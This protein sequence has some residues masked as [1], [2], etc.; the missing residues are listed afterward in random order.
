MVAA[1][2]V[3]VQ[4]KIC[5]EGLDGLRSGFELKVSTNSWANWLTFISPPDS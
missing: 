1:L 4:T 2:A 3:L 5:Q